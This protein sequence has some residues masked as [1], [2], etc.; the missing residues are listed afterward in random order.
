MKGKEMKRFQSVAQFKTYR[1]T[2]LATSDQSKPCIVICGGTGG[3][4]SGSNDLIRI[5]KR[6]IL[7]KDLHDKLDLRITGC[8]GFCEMDPFIIVE[9]G[10]NLY[11]K[12]KWRTFP[13]L[14]TR[15]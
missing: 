6:Q 12:L 10:Y 2:F 13:G 4:A 7:E 3:Q 9:P 14:S 8:L 11:P 5:I 1:K 15:P